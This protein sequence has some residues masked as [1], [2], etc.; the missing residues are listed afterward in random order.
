MN[1]PDSTPQRHVAAIPGIK[2]S[3]LVHN[4]TIENYTKKLL[5]IELNYIMLRMK[6]L[7]KK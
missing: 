6:I 5:N 1:L 7:G 3:E 2:L 4:L